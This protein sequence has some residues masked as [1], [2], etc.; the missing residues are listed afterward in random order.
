MRLTRKKS[1]EITRELWAWMKE[2][3]PCSKRDWPGWGKYGVMVNRCPLCEYSMQFGK[4]LTPSA[5][6]EL[7]CPLCPYFKRFGR[8]E[9]S[10]SPF[11]LWRRAYRM[12]DYDLTGRYSAAFLAQLEEL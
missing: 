8:C 5:R 10:E 11:A 9:D 4:L 7:R 3:P 6:G 1:L 12:C 2:H